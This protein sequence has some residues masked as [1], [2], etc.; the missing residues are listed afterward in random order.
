M[1][2]RRYQRKYHAVNMRDAI[3]VGFIIGM[4]VTMAVGVLASWVA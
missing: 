2:E 3:M 4:T 1:I